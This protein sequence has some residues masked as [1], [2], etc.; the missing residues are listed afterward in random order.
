MTAEG[1]IPASSEVASRK[2]KLQSRDEYLS[3]DHLSLPNKSQTYAV[4]AD[5]AELRHSLA[6]LARKSRCFSRSLRALW[7]AIKLFVFAWNSYF[8]E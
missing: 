5:T 4:E 3:V 2:S 1:D 8:A 7:L 6:R